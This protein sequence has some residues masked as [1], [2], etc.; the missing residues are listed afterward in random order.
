MSDEQTPPSPPPAEEK[1]K[2]RRASAN[3]KVCPFCEEPSLTRD[4]IMNGEHCPRCEV[5][6]RSE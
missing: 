4:W 6:M 5:R 3:K 1:P 2:K